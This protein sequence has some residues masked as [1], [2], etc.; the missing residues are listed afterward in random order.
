MAT[1][2]PVDPEFGRFIQG[3]KETPDGGA[4]VELAEMGDDSDVQELPDGSAIV[5]N[6]DSKTPSDDTDFYENLAEK[7]NLRDLSKLSTSYLDLID[8]D[9]EARK[10]R[11]KQYEE[12]IKRTGLGD[13]APGGAQ[14]MGASRVVHP[15]MAEACVD[16]AA[17]SMKE[18]FP[19]DGPVRTKIVGEATEEKEERA[20]RKRDWM[21]WQ[22]TEQIEEFRDEQEQMLTQLPLGGSQYMKMWFD[23]QKK[24]PCCE[25]VPIDNI[26]LPFSA[27][28]FY[29]AHRVTEQQD[30]TQYEFERRIERCLYRDV[31]FIRASAEPEETGAEKASNRIEGRSYNENEDGL[32]RVY[33]VYTWLEQED[34]S[35]S[36]GDWAP[37]IL[38][39]DATESKV[40]GLYRNWEEGDETMTKLDWMIEYKFIPWR[41]A[42]AIGLPHLIGGLSAALTG[43]LRA[44]LDTAHVNNSL[45]A[46]KLKG[47]KVSGQSQ[48]IEITQVTEIEAGP[49]IDD[50]RKIAMPM[51]FNPPSSVLFDLLGWLDGAAKGVV[52]TSEEKIADINSNA[53]VGTTQALIEQG[54]KVFSSI[55]ARMHD[56][57]RR[58]LKVL[59]RINRWYLKDMRRGELVEDLPISPEDFERNNDIVPVSDPNIFSETQR[60]AQSQA[61]LQLMSQY[62]QAFDQNAVLTRILKQMKIPDVKELMPMTAKPSEIDASEENAAM[63]LGKPAYAYPRQDQLAHIQAHLNY[64]LDPSLGSNPL[65][66]QAY[67]PLVMEHIKQHMVLWYTN[68]M[69]TYA[70]AGQEFD[71]GKYEDNKLV[72]EMD[73]AI[74]LA[75]DHLKLD[76]AEVFAQ[77]IPNLQKLGQLMATFKPPSPPMQGADIAYLQASMAETQRRALRDDK[78]LQLKA[79]EQEIKVAMNAEDNLTTERMKAAD[80][81]VDQVR[82]QKE[83]SETA[84]S[85]NQ[86]TQSNLGDSNGK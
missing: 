7:I 82:L 85:L 58:L 59:G 60:M 53:P 73:K 70:T 38:M 81:T 33:H 61:V 10:K 13:D 27:S 46:L 49:G 57:Q 11:D 31:E 80:L 50:I 21:N 1:D 15:V 25:F 26:L 28:N 40:L 62:P 45:T 74:S 65:I 51:P 17:S 30:I 71:F 37:Y 77:V 75:S 5:K 16:F 4:E 36:N 68:Q 41:G 47:A 43:A 8:K 78:E 20:E 55:H 63:S 86:A 32:R 84:V 12:G 64:A 67:I 18:L 76:T 54:A 2:F 56:S 66:A 39:I 79:K 35:Y 3:L 83:Q 42:Y 69:K 48:Q 19:S 6:P 24:R 72:K 9:R 22:L 23:E 44:L 14:F 29:T 52:S 34:D